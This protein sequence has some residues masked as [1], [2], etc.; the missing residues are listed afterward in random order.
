MRTLEVVAEAVFGRV[1]IHGMSVVRISAAPARQADAA[2]PLT[3]NRRRH[4]FASGA[5]H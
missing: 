2:H 1:G 5:S 4:L 3:Q